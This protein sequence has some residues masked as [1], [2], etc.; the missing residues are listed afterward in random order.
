M[1]RDGW[2]LMLTNLSAEE[3]GVSQLAA[4][5][6]AR[7]AVEIQFRAWKQALNLGK[8]LKRKSNE[9]HMQALVLAA[10]IAH[11]FGMKA[12]VRIGV[13]VGRAMVSY[14]KLYDSLASHLV[15]ARNLTGLCAFAPELRHTKRDKRRRKSPIE[16]GIYA[17]GCREWLEK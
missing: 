12:A 15:K 13:M 10:M 8:A 1:I 5:Y 11:Q 6:R 14:E 16:S 4:V 3:A 2:H 17:L 7:W 9:H